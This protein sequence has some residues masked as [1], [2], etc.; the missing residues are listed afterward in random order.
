MGCGCI[1]TQDGEQAPFPDVAAPVSIEVLA[2]FNVFAIAPIYFTFLTLS[3]TTIRASSFLWFNY[4]GTMI[5]I[6][7]FAGNIACN[8][9]FRHN[10]VLVVGGTTIN[11]IRSRIMPMARQGRLAVTA[12]VQTI[13][14]EITIFGTALNSIGINPVLR[15]DLEHGALTMLEQV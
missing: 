13:D 7:A 1:D 14:C 6:G 12:G 11:T 2:N 10:G 8:V 9:R 5:S 15:P 3:L 4:T